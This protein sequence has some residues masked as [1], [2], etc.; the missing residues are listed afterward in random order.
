VNGG[1]RVSQMCVRQP[2][3]R[4]CRNR[5]SSSAISID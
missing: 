4:G 1:R 5:L 2:S 3:V